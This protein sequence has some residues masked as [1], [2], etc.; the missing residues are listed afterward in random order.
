[1]S[2]SF[3]RTLATIGFLVG[4]AAGFVQPLDAP[5]HHRHVDRGIGKAQAVSQAPSHETYE[6]SAL[7]Y[8]AHPT[9]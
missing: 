3:R 6:T 9:N 5:V 7:A 8:K 1:M 4:L 2:R